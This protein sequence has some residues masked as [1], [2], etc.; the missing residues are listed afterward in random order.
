MDVILTLI[1]PLE[2]KFILDVSEPRM[3]YAVNDMMKERLLG[4]RVEMHQMVSRWK[5]GRIYVSDVVLRAFRSNLVV[6]HVAGARETNA[7]NVSKSRY[8]VAGSRVLHNFTNMKYGSSGGF[9]QRYVLSSLLLSH[10][11]I[12]HPVGLGR[13]SW[14]LTCPG[15]MSSTGRITGFGSKVEESPPVSSS[16][17]EGGYPQAKG[18]GGEHGQHLPGDGVPEP[19]MVGASWIGGTETCANRGEVSCRC[20]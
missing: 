18:R 4:Y 5:S 17:S 3:I 13:Q 11:G 6:N 1:P 12:D 14:F 10:N 7:R 16:E 8:T 9:I 20:G 2:D 19:V 15:A